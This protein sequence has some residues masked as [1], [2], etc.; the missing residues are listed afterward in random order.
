MERLFFDH[1]RAPW[2]ESD[3][4]NLRA[5]RRIYLPNVLNYTFLNHPKYEITLHTVDPCDSLVLSI[6]HRAEKAVVMHRLPLLLAAADTATTTRLA[7]TTKW[8]KSRF[9]RRMIVCKKER[10]VVLGNVKL[11]WSKEKQT[12]VVNVLL[13]KHDKNSLECSWRD[14]LIHG[15]QTFANDAELL[16]ATIPPFA[17]DD[18][19]V[20]FF[21]AMTVASSSSSSSS[22]AAAKQVASWLWKGDRNLGDKEDVGT[23]PRCSFLLA[24]MLAE[25]FLQFHE[26]MY[27][28][29]CN[30]MGFKPHQPLEA[31]EPP[32][33]QLA[34]KVGKLWT[35]SVLPHLEEVLRRTTSVATDIS[36]PMIAALI[37]NCWHEKCLP[38]LLPFLQEIH[39]WSSPAAASA[40]LEH[41][42]RLR[43]R[44]FESVSEGLTRNLHSA[45][46]RFLRQVPGM[47][48]V[49]T[50]ASY[51]LDEQLAPSPN[52][53]QVWIDGLPW[54]YYETEDET[55]D[56][57]QLY[58]RFKSQFRSK[59]GIEACFVSIHFDWIRR[60]VSFWTTPGR[61]GVWLA[62]VGRGDGN[63]AS[64]FVEAYQQGQVEWIDYA[65]EIMHVELGVTHRQIDADLWR[66]TWYDLMSDVSLKLQRR[67]EANRDVG[68]ACVAHAAVDTSLGLEH[69]ARNVSLS[70]R[71]LVDSFRVSCPEFHARAREVVVA[72]GVYETWTLAG[73]SG[74]V[75]NA[76]SIQRGLFANTLFHVHECSIDSETMLVNSQTLPR[77]GQRVKTGDVLAEIFVRDQ[78]RP[79]NLLCDMDEPEG[80]YVYSVECPD[81][82]KGVKII[83]SRLHLVSLDGHDTFVNRYG[84]KQRVVVRVAPEHMMPFDAAT[85]TR[86]DMILSPQDLDW[87]RESTELELNAFCVATGTVLTNQQ[88]SYEIESPPTQPEGSI[89]ASSLSCSDRWMVCPRTGR[90]LTAPFQLSTMYFSR[91]AGYGTRQQSIRRAR[92]EG[93]RAAKR[94]IA[95][96]D[97]FTGNLVS[98]AAPN[99]CVR[100]TVELELPAAENLHREWLQLGYHVH[101]VTDLMRP[102]DWSLTGWSTE[103][104]RL[105]N[106]EFTE[107]ERAKIV[108]E[109]SL[110]FEPDEQKRQRLM[111][112]QKKQEEDEEAEEEQ[113]KNKAAKKKDQQSWYDLQVQERR[114]RERR[115]FDVRA[116]SFYD[117]ASAT[118][119]IQ[120]DFERF[121]RRRQRLDGDDSIASSGLTL[122][123]EKETRVF[124][125]T[126]GESRLPRAHQVWRP[127][128]YGTSFQNVNS[129]RIMAYIDPRTMFILQSRRKFAHLLAA[130]QEK[131]STTAAAPAAATDGSTEAAAGFSVDQVR[132]KVDGV[133]EVGDIV[134]WLH[135]TMAQRKWK[136][137]SKETDNVFCIELVANEPME[138]LDQFRKVVIASQLWHFRPP[139]AAMSSSSLLAPMMINRPLL[140]MIPQP[141]PQQQ[142]QPLLVQPPQT[143]TPSVTFA[144]P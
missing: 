23:R 106:E 98:R 144:L 124:L 37:E 35:S 101:F 59:N 100:N 90:R 102:F 128:I 31:I 84:S 129:G 79:R 143:Q 81:P 57:G 141:P 125:E 7:A 63:F 5:L 109:V 95:Q 69:R 62:V 70:T 117:Q 67:G 119:M 131:M 121:W 50:S 118:P 134:H 13:K 122:Q 28:F 68:L 27:P 22:L 107:K 138:G 46:T 115:L 20:D 123:M 17:S 75:L 113:K 14:L 4:S 58:S 1:F 26:D 56:N 64:T 19:Q 76:S 99:T 86:P 8:K 72:V 25:W 136:I 49:Q 45:L 114:E 137:A 48:S 78:L 139:A 85:G 65:T 15:L 77:Q 33:S 112:K 89:P 91:A 142:Q 47:K 10:V 135:D 29:R 39:A 32:G 16:L 18:V 52:V 41:N 93:D 24:A 116:S 43:H 126:I 44:V 80:C 83:T 110:R 36:S 104:Q 96:I 73:A 66:A 42:Q 97:P 92:E 71:P 60:R 54:G 61:L 108:R 9:A 30:D 88:R 6:C 140:Q 11:R 21:R 94:L 53:C 3:A 2:M 38:Q 133:F 12:F 103:S 87:P 127:N 51:S 82:S 55:Y 132:E 130:R 40:F 111:A 34:A 120:L 74:V 105:F